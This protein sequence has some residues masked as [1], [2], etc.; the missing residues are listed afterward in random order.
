MKTLYLLIG[1]DRLY[2]YE[3]NGNSFERLYIEGNSFYEYDINNAKNSLEKL[4][5]YL[6]DEYNLDTKAEI[7]FVVIDN[8]DKIVSE[9][10]RQ[11]VGEYEKQKYDIECLIKNVSQKL[12]RDKSLMI[13][14]YGINFDGKNYLIDND[15][16]KKR[17][18]SLLGYTMQEDNL[19]KFVG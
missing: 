18:F 10:M 7:D 6:V 5:Q 12:S 16:I 4:M 13:Q 11:A 3:K 14:R 8:E 19:L 1:K 2:L 17:E 9:V 15:T